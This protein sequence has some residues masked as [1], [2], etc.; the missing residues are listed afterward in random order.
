M[1]TIAL[2]F[3]A[4]CFQLETLSAQ[5]SQEFAIAERTFHEEEYVAINV[6]QEF[7]TNRFREVQIALTDLGYSPGPIDGIFGPLT[8]AAIQRFQGEL[9]ASADGVLQNH[10]F[11][12]LKIAANLS[13]SDSER[14]RIQT[15]RA[16]R[17]AFLAVLN[18][19]E[20][21]P[22]GSQPDVVRLNASPP[23][24]L[25]ETAESPTADAYDPEKT[26]SATIEPPMPS[27]LFATLNEFPPENFLGYGVLSFKALATPRDQDRHEM[28]CQAFF[29]SLPRSTE[30]LEPRSQQFTTVWPVL[31]P[32]VSCDL[33]FQQR[34]DIPAAC[35]LA[36]ENYN[37][38]L[39]RLTID[40]ARRAGFSDE[41]TGPFLLGWL[42]AREFGEAEA[43]I[44]SLDL[45]LVHD[46]RQAS[47]LFNEWKWEI[48]ADPLLR[49]VLFSPERLRHKIRQLSVQHG[50]GVFGIF[51]GG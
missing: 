47:I 2:L 51:F 38:E 30:L 27:R 46:F 12:I 40:A 17:R 15:V 8:E 20:Q 29:A 10:Q 34:E 22:A 31:S 1:R 14:T 23:P 41:G 39:A 33:N 35:E 45:S 50:P 26:V 49:E 37:D 11:M 24:T 43:L 28:I 19:R 18:E 25:G 3:L 7:P 4:L 42:P 32:D 21:S 5:T 36:V 44:V 9:N 48:E 6:A 16:S 13:V